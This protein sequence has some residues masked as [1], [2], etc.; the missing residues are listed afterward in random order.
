MKDAPQYPPQFAPLN[1]PHISLDQ[2]R[3]L[4]A[5]VESGGY[6][7]AAEALYKSQSSVSYAVQKIESL[8]GLKAFEVQGRKAVLTPTGQMLYRR[9]QALVGEAAELERAAKNLSAGWE[10]EI[11]VAVEILFPTQVLLSSLAAFNRESPGTRIELIES[12]LSGTGDA[13]PCRCNGAKSRR[14]N[15]AR[16]RRRSQSGNRQRRSGPGGCSRC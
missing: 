15:A 12:V 9:A 5:V 7:Q 8:L 11:G 16:D 6:A 10:A 14:R 2:W 3:A 1:T 13:R 4:I